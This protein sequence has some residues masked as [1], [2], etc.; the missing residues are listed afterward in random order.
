M[1]AGAGSS[2][3]SQHAAGELL[4]GLGDATRVD[5]LEITWLGGSTQILTDLPVNRTLHIEEGTQW[6]SADSR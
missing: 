6:T 4:F 1:E 5:S 2:Y 3:L